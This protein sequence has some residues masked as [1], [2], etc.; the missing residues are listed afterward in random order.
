M[1][2]KAGSGI[3]ILT[4]LV[5]YGAFLPALLLFKELLSRGHTVSLEVI[6]QYYSADTQKVFENTKAAFQKNV[7]LVKIAS[8]LSA[9]LE[10]NTDKSL[11][12]PLM[13][14]W[15]KPGCNKFVCF[16]GLWCET[17]A[18]YLQKKHTVQPQMIFCKVDAGFSSAWKNSSPELASQYFT[19]FFNAAAGKIQYSIMPPG[20][21]PVP[22]SQR[23]NQ[24][25]IHGGGWNLGNYHQVAQTIPGELYR[26]FIVQLPDDAAAAI[27]DQTEAVKATHKWDPLHN[28]EDFYSFPSYYASNS[29]Q[30][31][32]NGLW[33]LISQCKA[34]ISKPG[35]MTLMDSLVTATPLVMLEP[36]GKNEEDNALLWQQLGLG[37]RYTDWEATG[38]DESILARMHGELLKQQEQSK[39]FYTFIEQQLL[40]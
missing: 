31:I 24:L 25:L 34:I 27:S 39:D 36:A 22:F 3:A 6:E 20:V 1:H 33:Q 7:K 17:M 30:K 21:I 40:K 11:L 18:A 9:Q 26:K 28:K 35:G 14:S 23:K 4:S 2:N 19:S 13:Q 29:P 37:I 38:F 10:K 12:E 15:E 32:Y 8:A 5:G 16:S